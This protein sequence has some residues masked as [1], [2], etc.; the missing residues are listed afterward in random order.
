MRPQ[1]TDN[2]LQMQKQ[3]SSPHPRNRTV[4]RRKYRDD[5]R[6]TVCYSRFFVSISSHE[7]IGVDSSQ[8]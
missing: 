8:E 2:R 7:E 5:C 1:T 4:I 3:N 6:P